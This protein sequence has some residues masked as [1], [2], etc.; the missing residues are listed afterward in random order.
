[1]IFRLI[2]KTPFLFLLTV[3]VFMACSKRE[4]ITSQTNSENVKTGNLNLNEILGRPTN[5]SVAINI[6]FD[7][8]EEVFWEIGTI[9]GDY[10]TKTQVYT[11]PKGVPTIA[12]FS[13]LI[14]NTKY[15]YRARYRTAGTTD[16]F[17]AGPEHTFHTQRT[18]GETFIFTVESDPHPYDKKGCHNL[19]HITLQNQLNDNPDFM[20]D[21]GDTF[22]D[23]HNAA[24]ITSDQVKQLHLN[25][26]A[27]FGDVCH[28]MPLFFCPGNHEGELGY[29]L[30]QSP[31][32][33]LAV[34]GSIWRHYYYP[35]PYPDGF[36]SGNSVVEGHLIGKPENYYSWKWGDALFMVLDVYRYA[37]SGEKP[38]K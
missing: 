4:P 18:P 28:S 36:Y 6:L 27:Y 20:L 3:L 35:N 10:K 21:L 25:D 15:Y 16:P 23:D 9:S 13:N 30:L 26:R 19:W 12:D 34:Y 24:T 14:Q 2:Q 37:V 22:G 38:E 7:Q 8:P 29:Y 5:S 31:P 1:M 11:S 32:N 17:V 33:N